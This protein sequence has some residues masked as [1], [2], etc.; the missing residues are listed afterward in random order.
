M[1]FSQ[2]D[3]K[4]FS[5]IKSQS[6]TVVAA[7]LLNYL[8]TDWSALLQAAGYENTRIGDL[9][10]QASLMLITTKGGTTAPT[11]VMKVYSPFS[12]DDIVKNLSRRVTTGQW[13]GDTG[14]LV[15][16]FTSSAQSASSGDW[17]Y[18][19]YNSN[20]DVS[21]SAEIQFSV[22]YGH[23][24]GGGYPRI[25]VLNTSKEPTRAIYAQYRNILLDPE[26]DEFTFANDWSSDHI[27]VIN[28]QRSRLK[29]K[30]DAGN[31]E[32]T[33]TTGSTTIT[34]IDD[35]TDKFD[36]NV[37][38]GGRVYNVVSGTLNVGS[39]PTIQLA[40]A[41]EPSGG[42][43]LFYPDRGII[44]LNP[45][46][47]EAHMSDFTV[48]T[49]SNSTT[50]HDNK[51]YFFEMINGGASFTARNEEIV[52]STHYFVRA[53]NRDF[54]FSNNSTYYTSSDG[55]LKVSSF[56][57]DPHTYITTIGLYNDANE[58]LAVAKLSQPILKSFDRE[59]LVKVKL[60]F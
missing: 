23:K 53:K 32:L 18:D 1:A 3:I 21:S 25:S 11:T 31:W 4:T 46:A 33:L 27:F 36:Q 59:A 7:A 48:A 57:G 8:K 58:L 47:L 49:A 13:T 30:M 14:S 40:A 54:N 28:I 56:V 5:N 41:S 17:Y 9:L 24:N 45:H 12:D 43:G 60:D 29:Q 20:P 19:I 2:S 55:T 44:I 26:D 52:T 42:Y 39:D 37:S 38:E 10:E 35:S 51:Y 22:A 6:N 16:F 50:I 15:T 34:L